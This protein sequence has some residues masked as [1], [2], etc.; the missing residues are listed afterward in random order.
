MLL[1]RHDNEWMPVAYA[2]RVMSDA[3]TRYAQI[4]K[5]M[6]AISFACEHFHQYIFGQVVEVETDHKPLV[7]I[8]KKSLND[9]PL[10]LQRLLLRVQKYDLRIGYTPGKFM[11]TADAL[12]RGTDMSTKLTKSAQEEDLKVYVDS[13]IKSLPI[14]DRKLQMIREETQNDP[15]LQ[16]L[17]EVI[18]TGFP[19]TRTECPKEISEYWNIRTELSLCDGIIMKTDCIVIPVTLRKEMLTKIHTGHLGIEK[20]RNRAKQVMYWPGMYAQIEEMVNSFSTCI[21]FRPKHL[22]NRLN[23]LNHMIY[24]I[25]H[26]KKWEQIC[27]YSMEKIILCYV[28]TTPII[29]K[30]VVCTMCQVNQSLMQ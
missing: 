18:V 19:E 10:R 3:E 27:V 21:K 14:S 30:C 15:K 28:I 24:V 13:V 1:Q 29:Q 20:C 9:C 4:E 12:S 8:F 17:A 22:N 5:E 25:I 16:L 6:L 11:H 23:H 7:S 2:S 26:G